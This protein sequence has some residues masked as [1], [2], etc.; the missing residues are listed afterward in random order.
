M[1]NLIT[2][3]V[4]LLEKSRT[5]L[6]FPHKSSSA[7]LPR[8]MLGRLADW[9]LLGAPAK[10]PS[11]Q[12]R[13]AT[14]TPACWCLNKQD[15]LTC[16]SAIEMCG[17]LL[18]GEMGRRQNSSTMLTKPTCGFS[19][20]PCLAP[21]QQCPPW[22]PA[23]P[24]PPASDG[25]PSCRC[26][27]APSGPVCA[28]LRGSRFPP[29]I[30]QRAMHLKGRLLYST[31]ILHRFPEVVQVIESTLLLTMGLFFLNRWFISLFTFCRG[32]TWL[33]NTTL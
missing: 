15:P 18:A 33:P 28:A 11:S 25:S 20:S 14:A 10:G 29:C 16:H 24:A 1:P 19:A 3:L 4:L 8:G 27:P 6:F 9:H 2:L 30:S 5:S 31:Q 17:A 32:K 26:Q 22:E 13:V 7:L 21:C 12:P 23:P